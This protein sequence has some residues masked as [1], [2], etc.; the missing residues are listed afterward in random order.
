MAG[1]SLAV[2]WLRLCAFKNEDSA[3][4]PFQCGWHGF[5]SLSGT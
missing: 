5:D 4:L 3:L 2:Q 1:T